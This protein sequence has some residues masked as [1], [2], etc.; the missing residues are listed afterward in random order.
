MHPLVQ[1][2]KVVSARGLDGEFAAH[3]LAALGACALGPLHIYS[4]WCS[5][6]AGAHAKDLP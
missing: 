6:G 1:Q 2:T 4:G 5:A 3:R